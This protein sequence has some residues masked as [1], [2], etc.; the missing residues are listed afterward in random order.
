MSA[1][2]Q[3]NNWRR[4]FCACNPDDRRSR[5]HS[6]FEKSV[7]QFFYERFVGET[8][9]DVELERFKSAFD[10]DEP[11]VVVIDNL[12][13]YAS[14]VGLRGMRFQHVYLDLS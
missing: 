9:Q 1:V 12:L 14:D 3:P 4:V 11:N 7:A 10:S 6:F 2:I 5:D 13:N 8:A